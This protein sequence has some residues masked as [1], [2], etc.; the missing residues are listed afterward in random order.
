MLLTHHEIKL[1]SIVGITAHTQRGH[2]ARATL[3]AT[4]F[5]TKAIL[6]AMEKDSGHKLEGLAVDGGMSN[7]NL[8]MQTQADIIG[9]PVDRPVMRE[10]TALGAAIAA[11]FAVDIWKEFDE[12]KEIN[13]EDRAIF[14]P[15]V[16]KK[17][18]AKM[19]KKWEQAVEMSKGWVLDNADDEDD[20]ESE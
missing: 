9:I 6:D 15:H 1:T 7:S 13:R 17:K 19:F 5:Q 4:C 18:S 11:G 16:A 12:L 2:I 3:E 10:T 20:E 8:C 14:T